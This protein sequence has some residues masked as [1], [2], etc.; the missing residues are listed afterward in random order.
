MKSQMKL[1]ALFGCCALLSLFAFDS[2]KDKKVIVIDAGHGGHDSGAVVDG[3]QEK[4]IVA[5]IAE[6]IKKLNSDKD[7]EIVLVRDEDKAME[8]SERVAII[9]K[10][11]PDLVI[12]LHV[13][14][15]SKDKTKDQTDAYVSPTSKFAEQ[16]K[17]E[18][19]KIL[20]K[21]SGQQLVK[22]KIMEAPFYILKH[23]ECPVAFIELGFLSNEKNR[24]YITSENGQKE[25][26]TNI[27][28]AVK[29]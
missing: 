4:A 13:N 2:I 21:I 25:I 5:S 7:I 6:K 16:S 3:F 29:K 19:G 23:A 11:N 1:A 15:H 24:K 20:D 8:L 22:G 18:A 28:K 26:A 9:N 17:V 12:S 10:V 27:L 14:S